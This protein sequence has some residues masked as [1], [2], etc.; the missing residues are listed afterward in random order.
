VI[1]IDKGI[2][3]PVKEQPR[4]KYPWAEM[5]PGDSIEV[6]GLGQTA[7]ASAASFQRNTGK[8]FAV[9]RWGSNTRIW[10]IK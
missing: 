5:V 8:R 3:L 2:A 1:A 9:R 4:R 10:R 7:R 6:P